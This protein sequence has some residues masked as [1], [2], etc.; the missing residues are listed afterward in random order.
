MA[1][2]RRRLGR[3]LGPDGGASWVV[4]V[5][6][7]GDSVGLLR[8]LHGLGG[9]FGLRLTVAHLDHGVRGEEAREDAR[10]VAALAGSLGLPFEGG[11]W[12]P[13]R[14]GNFEA[15]ARRARYA[16]LAEVALRRGAS[17]VAVG[18]TRDDQAETMLHRIVRGT[19][20]RGLA[21]IP[22]RRPLAPGVELVRPLLDASRDAIRA[23]LD[24]LGQPYR[25]DPTNR[26]VSRTRAR[27]RHELLPR[28]VGSYNPRAVDAIVR[29]GEQAAANRRLIDALAA[30]A[31]E[32]A[33][34]E[35]GPG[36]IVLDRAALAAIDPDLI[37]EVIRHAWRNAGWPE[38]GID[39]D[40]WNRVAI[41]LRRGEAASHLGAGVSLRLV[42]DSAVLDRSKEGPHG[43]ASP[44][45]P[46]ALDAPGAVD[47]GGVR[48]EAGEADEGE[49]AWDEVIDRDRVRPPL[50]V[51]S[52]E[53]GDRF[54]PL[55]MGGRR[56]RLVDF[57]RLRGV[58]AAR[59]KAVP[60]LADREGIVWV[61]GH[62]IAD[63]V[64]TTEGTSRRL[65]LRRPV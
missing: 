20:L 65:G 18:H 27:I 40:G 48:I 47:W 22:D 55:G 12:S 1:T 9:A 43:P 41:L 28:L 62:R 19:G 16:W 25:E 35:A 29:L 21:G 58:P 36:R 5:S 44:P 64:R 10:F 32:K 63:R 15:D 6:G 60:I 2:V 14:E 39:S 49:G 30:S 26:D 7:G 31:A 45:P 56:Q 17:A 13:A 54:E 3:W 33:V 42:G 23:E 59:R 50:V 4:A 37:V 51:R 46:A 11:S 38:G 61:V 52:P 24:R 57:L 34:R 53:P 8:A